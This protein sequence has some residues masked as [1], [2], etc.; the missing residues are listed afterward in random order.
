M[1]IGA[2]MTKVTLKV[3]QIVLGLISIKRKSKAIKK[4]ICIYWTITKN[5]L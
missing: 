1:V 3:V 2:R 5:W 4:I